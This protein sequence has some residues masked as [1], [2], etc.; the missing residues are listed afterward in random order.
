MVECPPARR[1]HRRPGGCAMLIDRYEPED[2]FARVP[3]L[4]DQTDPVLVQLDRLLDDDQLVRRV[5]TDLAHRYR[6]TLVHGR[7]STPAAVLLRCCCACW[8]SSISLRGATPRRW[9]GWPIHWCCAGAALVLRWCC[10]GA[11][12]VLRWCCRVYFQR[13]LPACTSSAYPT[14]R[15]GCAGQRPSNRRRCRPWWT[16]RRHWPARP[17]SRGRVNC[18]STARVYRQPS[19]TRGTAA[20]WAMG[21]EGSRASSTVPSH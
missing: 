16:G 9:S 6:L 20:G 3:E 18:G 14:R 5:R 19:I 4:A 8:S 7:H 15:R 17:T 10:A 11:A 21:C 1:R 13:V 12:L 2:V